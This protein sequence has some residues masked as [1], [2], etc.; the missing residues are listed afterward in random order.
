MITEVYV[1]RARLEDL[2]TQLADDFRRHDVQVIYGTIR[3]IEKDDESFLAWARDAWACVVV[4]LHVGHNPQAIIKAESDFQRIID[5]A[6][7]RE[8]SYYLTYH[9]WARRDQVER[10][11]PQFARFLELKRK[12]DP[13]EVFQSDW[14]RHYRE[15]LA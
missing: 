7:E 5:R 2:L 12:Y 1:P 9:R 15:L 8:G 4:N 13:D 14:Y 10:C 6:I 11:Y 3:L